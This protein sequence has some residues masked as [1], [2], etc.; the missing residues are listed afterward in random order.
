MAAILGTLM[1][2]M[3][4]KSPSARPK[5]STTRGTKKVRTIVDGGNLALPYDLTYHIRQEIQC[6]G[7]PMWCRV[8]SIHHTVRTK[9][10]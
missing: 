6:L 4:Y 3:L 10:R 2:H 8:L 9:Y 7:N 5:I 1:H